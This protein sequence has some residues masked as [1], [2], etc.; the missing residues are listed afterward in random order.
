MNEKLANLLRDYQ[1]RYPHKLEASFPHIIDKILAGWGTPDLD[2]YLQSLM[3][4]DRPGRQG[5][6]PEV[7]TEIFRLAMVHSELGLVQERDRGAWDQAAETELTRSRLE[8]K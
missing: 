6:P 8:D 1:D 3:I 7:A 2:R 4:A 5:F